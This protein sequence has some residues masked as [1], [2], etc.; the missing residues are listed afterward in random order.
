MSDKKF[1]TLLII[2]AIVFWF[3]LN[4]CVAST[5][6][7]DE[8]IIVLEPTSPP[9]TIAFTATIGVGVSFGDSITVYSYTKQ[10]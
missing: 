10:N 6:A 5:L 9:P 7:T 8:S 1:F 4:V 3:T 2:F